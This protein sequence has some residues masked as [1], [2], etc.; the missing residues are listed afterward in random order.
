MELT[1]I[2]H[3]GK[4][5]ALSDIHG[6]LHSFIICLRDCAKVIKKNKEFKNIDTDLEINLNIDISDSDQNYDESLGYTWCGD[7]SY[8]VICGDMID[9]SR[10]NACKNDNN[11][12]CGYY[13]QIEIKLLRFIN[14]INRQAMTQ[15]GRM[16]KLLGNHELSSILGYQLD[17][18][19]ESDLNIDNYYR[20]IKRN[21][22]FMVGNEGFNL[23]LQ[24]KCYILIKINNTI[25]VHGQ[26]PKDNICEIN[27]INNF[28][29]NSEH[30][31]EEWR[32][33]LLIYNQ[34]NGLLWDREWSHYK[35]INK[36]NNNEI[37]DIIKKDLKN[38]M[39]SNDIDKLRVVLG[40]CP[41]NSSSVHD[42]INTTM[43]F[44]IKQD[45]NSKTYSS[46]EYYTCSITPSKQDT[47]FGIT[48]QC[49]KDKVNDHTDFYVYHV[50]ISLSRGF[51]R[52]SYYDKISSSES[53]SINNENKYL[54]SKTPQVL[55]IEIINNL[56]FVTIIKSKM[57]NTRIHL[58]RPNY[59]KM[60]K[61]FTSLSLSNKEYDKKKY[62]KYKIKYLK[63]KYYL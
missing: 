52:I 21:D 12:I 61:N 20:C 43:T 50:D 28:I 16:I 40:H 29:N 30:I 56:D 60:I 10:N 35:L 8:I 59:E 39:N 18:V 44:K 63:L 36:R 13:P 25:F 58:Q 42:F 9:P 22:I 3:N 1:E 38:F 6:D 57:R 33:K 19:F 62:K 15:C 48:M 45:E 24:D 49:P 17:N 32:R 47:I 23:L 41:Q 7:N 51:D 5:Y 54:F 4:I 53:E 37:C 55:C 14:N 31:L 26:L 2:Y 11:T 34:G 46:K 27:E